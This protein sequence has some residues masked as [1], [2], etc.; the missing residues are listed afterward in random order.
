MRPDQGGQKVDCNH[1]KTAWEDLD[2][3]SVYVD[4]QRGVTYVHSAVDAR[5]CGASGVEVFAGRN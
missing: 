3:G 5:G 1:N 4:I 2:P